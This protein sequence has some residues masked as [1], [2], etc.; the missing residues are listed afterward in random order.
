MHSFG[1]NYHIQVYEND[2]ERIKQNLDLDHR[3]WFCV[4]SEVDP[5]Q[6][7]ESDTK[8]AKLKGTEV[9]AASGE[10]KDS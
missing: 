1:Q 4:K 8:K 6:D 9:E 3:T 5:K 2:P 10:T 7:R